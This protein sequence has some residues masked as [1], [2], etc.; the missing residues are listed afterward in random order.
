MPFRGKLDFLKIIVDKLARLAYLDIIKHQER[1]IESMT[2]LFV[3]DFPADLHKKAKMQA[4]EEDLTLGQLIIKAL[5]EY[6]A[7]ARKKGGK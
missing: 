4:L 5:N 2:T 3:R 7:R 6:L 1:G